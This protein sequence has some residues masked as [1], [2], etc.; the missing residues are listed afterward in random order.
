M[1]WAL[2]QPQGEAKWPDAIARQDERREL[3]VECLKKF[4]QKVDFRLE[5]H[6][7][8]KM[9][10]RRRASL[11][12]R[13]CHWQRAASVHIEVSNMPILR[14]IP[15]TKTPPDVLRSDTTLSIEQP[16]CLRKVVAGRERKVQNYHRT[17]NPHGV[18]LE[19]WWKQ[20]FT[21][22]CQTHQAHRNL[23]HSQRRIE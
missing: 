19:H 1:V 23:A 18:V 22:A 4:S 11:L 15:A 6:A 8:L 20:L 3:T 14:W 2:N 21:L 5:G 10:L 16:P 17:P 12:Q 9:S 7:G 13:C